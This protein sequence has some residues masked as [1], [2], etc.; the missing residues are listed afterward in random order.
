MT[1]P[2]RQKHVRR[3]QVTVN[4]AMFVGHVHGA[5]QRSQQPGA[6]PGWLRA[7]AQRP[8]EA[9]PRDERQREERLPLVLADLVDLHDVRVVQP[10]AFP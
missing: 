10:M 1:D 9:A 3:L 4:D 5:G 7:A 2:A 8:V 6:V